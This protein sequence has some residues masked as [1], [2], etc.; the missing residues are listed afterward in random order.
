MS[1]DQERYEVL[2]TKAVDGVIS[3]NE[4]REFEDLVN[5]DPERAAE[6]AD[7]QSIK[8]ETD[9]MTQRILQTAQ[10][11]PPRES[12]VIKA[13][14]NLSF[15]LIFSALAG[16]VTVEAYLFFG[17]T[18]I[19]LSMKAVGG[20]FGAGIAGLFF[21]VLKTRLAGLKNDPYQEIDR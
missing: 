2:V 14:L 5:A 10:S 20:G 19:S 21:H 12:G 9:A 6:L 17:A 13:G 16:L 18:D 11:M 15:G 1:T 3:E 4:S 7:F 8:Q